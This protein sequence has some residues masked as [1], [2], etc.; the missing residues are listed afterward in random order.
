ML[1]NSMFLR[2]IGGVART[3]VEVFLEK[4]WSRKTR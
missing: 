4:E 3:F 1:G 2:I